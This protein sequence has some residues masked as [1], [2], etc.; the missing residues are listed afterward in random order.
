M[1]LHVPVHKTNKKNNQLMAECTVNLP[2][3]SFSKFIRI[4]NKKKYLYS[5]IINKYILNLMYRFL[6]EIDGVHELM[7]QGLN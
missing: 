7:Q 6:P 2:F 5:M 3:L 1:Q 4:H